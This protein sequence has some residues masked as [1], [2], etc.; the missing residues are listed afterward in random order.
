MK[1][2]TLTMVSRGASDDHR[3]GP[4]S[5]AVVDHARQQRRAFVDGE[6]ARLLVAE[7][8]GDQ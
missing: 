3:A 5:L 6:R 4:A 7:H 2:L 1:R 8:D